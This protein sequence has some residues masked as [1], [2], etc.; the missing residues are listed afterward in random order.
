MDRKGLVNNAKNV[1][2][3]N[4]GKEKV[5]EIKDQMKKTWVK[6]SDYDVGDRSTLESSTSNSFENWFKAFGLGGVIQENLISPYSSGHLNPK[7]WKKLY[8]GIPD[9]LDYFLE[10]S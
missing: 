8:Y 5:E 1:Q 6:K 10:E 2:S 3:Y 9:D 4:K 7:I